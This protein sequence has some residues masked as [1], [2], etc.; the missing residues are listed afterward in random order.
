MPIPVSDIPAVIQPDKDRMDFHSI[1]RDNRKFLEG[2]RLFGD[3]HKRE[4]EDFFMD[5]NPLLQPNLQPAS[6]PLQ[7][8]LLKKE[9]G[10][11][12]K[13]NGQAVGGF[14]GERPEGVPSDVDEMI[15]NQF[16]P[17]P[18]VQCRDCCVCENCWLVLYISFK[19]VN[20]MHLSCPM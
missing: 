14:L 13:E 19:C 15:R 4:W 12:D 2:S 9:Q 16:G 11:Q 20:R 7:S 1:K 17:V 5:E 10:R 8:V 6:W 18:E 3:A